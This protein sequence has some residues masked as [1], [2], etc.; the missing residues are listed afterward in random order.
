M[1]IDWGLSSLNWKSSCFGAVWLG[2]TLCGESEITDPF[3]IR[4][5]SL[6]MLFV[7]L[8]GLT[9]KPEFIVDDVDSVFGIFVSGTIF[10]LTTTGVL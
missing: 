2:T 7:Y 6:S 5:G 1:L 3:S 8:A 4:F 9:L 10:C